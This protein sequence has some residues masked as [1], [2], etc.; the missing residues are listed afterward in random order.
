MTPHARLR[1]IRIWLVLFIIGLVLSGATAFPLVTEV[2]W[3]DGLLRESRLPAPDALVD[4]IGT[5][6]VALE[7]ADR[8]FPFLLYGTD[9][10][11][12]AHLV[13]AMAFYGPFRDPVRNLWVIH[14]AMLCCA[15]VIPLALIMAPIRELPWWWI[16]IDCSFG[17][18]GIVPLLIVRRHILALAATAQPTPAPSP[19]PAAA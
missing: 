18:F 1:R 6:R 4:F 10:L 16:P 7:T 13:I 8:D 9:W 11:A 2:R 12:F 14:W 19:A 5:V 3:L 17:V 15:A